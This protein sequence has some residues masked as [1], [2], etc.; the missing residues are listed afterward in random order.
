MSE[1]RFQVDVGGLVQL[2]SQNL[3]SGATVFVRELLQ[4][5]VDAVT[6]RREQ[7]P[8]APGEIRFDPYAFG[9]QPGLRVT[10]TGI[11]LTKQEAETLLATIG[12]SSKRD[13][14]LGEGRQEFLGQFGI[15]FLSCFLVADTVV[16]K[17]QSARPGTSPIVWTGHAD[18]TFQIQETAENLPIGTTIELRPRAGVDHLVSPEAI[19]RLTKEFGGL[20]SFDVAVRVKVAG[21]LVWRRVT[22]G[23]LPWEVDYQFDSDRRAA[24]LR[25]C[26][27]NLNFTPLAYLD[28]SVS[29][30]GISGIAYILPQAVGRG[31]GR[32]HVYVKQMLVSQK[33]TSILPEWAFFVRAVINADGLATTASREQLREDEVLQMAREELGQQ[34]T[35]WITK[36]VAEKNP[37]RLKFLETHHLALRAMALED[38]TMLKL[39]AETVP[40]ETTNGPLTLAEAADHGVVRYAPT[41]EEY[42]RIAPVARAQGMLV[43]N[44]GYVYDADLIARLDRLTGWQAK[45]LAAADVSQ[46]LSPVPELRE[47]A[48]ATALVE[49]ADILARFDCAVQ[50]K[51]FSPVDV[52]AIILHDQAAE[53]QATMAAE[54]QQAD[55]LWGGIIDN[56]V[57]PERRHPRTLVFNDQNPTVQQLLATQPGEVFTAGVQAIFFAAVMLAGEGLD[58]AATSE[59]NSALGVLLQNSLPPAE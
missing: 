9:D 16:V 21:E 43:V 1:Q 38:E 49:A 55:D 3:Y 52:P 51:T 48:V 36:L 37:L 53:Q 59:F 34:L 18:G 30:L 58:G 44:G 13:E 15:G 54:Q 12:N 22:M 6:A 10:D 11:G 41:T 24:M 39:V 35:A 23:E 42:R 31:A 19:S 40:F 27:Q 17:S 46:I 26:E 56:F 45:P 28:L 57:E 25:Y 50:L 32:H 14:L 7:D 33:E 8:S 2:L 5:A 29:L 20:L 4:N 47:H